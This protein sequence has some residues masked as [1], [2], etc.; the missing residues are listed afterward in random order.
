MTLF[1]SI[2]LGLVQGAAEF[3]PISS[4]G[5]LVLTQKLLGLNVAEHSYVSFDVLLHI[6]TLISVV[7]IFW[8]DIL[9]LF[10]A[11]FKMIGDLFTKGK[12]NINKSEYRK[13]VVMLFLASIPLVVG[14]FFES[15]IEHLF[16]STIFVACALLL[17]SVILYLT[18]VVKQ[19][20]KTLTNSKLIDGLYVG[21]AQ[22]VAIIPG[23]S[24]SGSTIFAGVLSG[25]TRQ[26][27]VKFSFLLSGI[28]IIGATILQFSEITGGMIAANIGISAAGVAVAA[29]VGIL[30][31]KFLTRL[32]SGRGY[33]VFAYYC[34][35]VS[36]LTFIYLR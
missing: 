20:K 3:L 10:V 4:S 21:L 30:S 35:L 13:L 5:H 9:G 22:L 34:V 27:A 14:A 36:I 17:T 6:G 26:F 16:S 19:G 11:L 18:D 12:L 32:A 8:K 31:I 15:S 1:Q 24:R 28:A 25:M 33:R 7:V 29:I 23:L 2:I